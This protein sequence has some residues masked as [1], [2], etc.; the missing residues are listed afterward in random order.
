MKKCSMVFSADKP[1]PRV[2]Q[3]F[4]LIELLVVIA[5]IAI[6]AAMLLP[7]L[8][9]AKERAKRTQCLNNVK[10]L[11]LG[12]TM[13]AGDNGDW[14]PTWGGNPAPFNA[15]TKNDVW[16]PSYMRWIVFGG[17]VSRQVPQDNGALKALGGNFENLGYLFSARFVGNG[18]VFFCPSYPDKSQLSEHYYSRGA[19]A[20]AVAG[21]LITIVQSANGNIGVRSSYTFN[22]VVNTVAGNNLRQFQK[23]GQINARRA[24]IMDYLDVDMSDPMNCAHLRSKGW[25]IG[26]TD[27]SVAFSKPPPATY[28]AIQSMPANIQ[29]LEINTKYLPIMEQST[30]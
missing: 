20:P 13:Y 10:Q 8:G 9:S 28:S 14:F 29:M 23:A 4:T 22:P 16:L 17:T 30:K 1:A 25:N 26:F 24:F 7:A 21:P 5:I 11:Y 2:R 15:R 12:C 6:L 18:K 3:G 19:P 27:G